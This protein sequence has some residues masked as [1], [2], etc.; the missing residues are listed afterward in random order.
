MNLS[1][2]FLLSAVVFLQIPSEIIFSLILLGFSSLLYHNPSFFLTSSTTPYY[3][4]IFDQMNII[5]TCT[6][7]SFESL[8]LS[9]HFMSM[10]LLEQFLFRT[11]YTCL[12]VYFISFLNVISTSNILLVLIISCLYVHSRGR[13]FTDCE[14]YLWHFLQGLYIFLTLKRNFPYRFDFFKIGIRKSNQ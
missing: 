11:C 12:F 7:I 6:T 13:D 3:F 10:Y 9:I 8:P 4:Y 14:R 2:L 1:F 5:N